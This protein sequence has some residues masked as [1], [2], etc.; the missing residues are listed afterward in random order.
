MLTSVIVSVLSPGASVS[1]YT[2]NLVNANAMKHQIRDIQGLGPVKAD[3]STTP[4][5]SVD[6]ELYNGSSMGK[7]NIVFTFGLNPAW[8]AGESMASMRKDLYT[9]FMPKRWVNLEFVS[10][11]MPNVQ[12]EGYVESVEPNMFSSDPEIQVSIICPQPDFVASTPSGVGGTVETIPGTPVPVTIEYE[13][14]IPVGFEAVVS[15]T[16]N[17]SGKI[18]IRNV[19]VVEEE[20]SMS[21]DSPVVTPS[22]HLLFST[23]QGKKFARV[24]S[25]T[26]VVTNLLG[27]IGGV[28]EWPQLVPGD[29]TF[30][31]AADPTGAY[32]VPDN[33]WSLTYSARYGGL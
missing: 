10:T 4:F 6:G 18:Y 29:N 23:V 13:G 1:P 22:Q 3:I 12:I 20:F 19:G 2:L 5:G 32:A 28:I 7:R 24:M 17:F 8:S 30:Y 27:S 14:T 11:H 15:S 21:E 25:G 31:I 9:Y 26:T 33:A 16:V